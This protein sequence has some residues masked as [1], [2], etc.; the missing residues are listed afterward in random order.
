MLRVRPA[1]AGVI[2][3]ATPPMWSPAVPIEEEHMPSD[4][5]RNDI[6]DCEGRVP[7]LCGADVELG[8]FVLGRYREDGT[9]LEA[10]R[11]LLREID[12][13]PNLRR[14][15]STTSGYAGGYGQTYDPQDW[16]R[17]FLSS[18]AGCAYIDLNHLEICLPEV[19]SAF[20]HVA[21]WHAML[22]LTRRALFA[23]NERLPPGQRIQVLVNNSDGQSNSY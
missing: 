21:A 12:G 15:N 3:L 5:Y 9:G 1:G 7:K 13:V 10:S 14:S 16:G 2:E 11:A 19:V 18:N 22:R 8:N 23:A 20:E 4:D 17:K 6:R